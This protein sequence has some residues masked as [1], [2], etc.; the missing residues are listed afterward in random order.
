MPAEALIGLLTPMQRDGAT[1]FAVGSG[2]LLSVSKIK[3]V[4]G[5]A[6][7]E[8]PWRAS[9]GAGIPRLRFRT[10]DALLAEQARVRA[11]EALAAWAPSVRVTSVT[12]DREDTTLAIRVIYVED[13][14]E[15]VA[16]V[17]LA[18]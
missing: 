1:D 9:F 8:L 6:M 15:R 16:S 12:V 18:E 11:I 2:A 4:L 5:T 17:A 14:E 10:N 3:Q 13:G 7:G